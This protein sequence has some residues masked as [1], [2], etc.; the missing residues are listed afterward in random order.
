[1]TPASSLSQIIHQ[2]PDATDAGDLPDFG[3][4]PPPSLMD[5]QSGIL[6]ALFNAPNGRELA[7]RQADAFRR[8][9]QGSRQ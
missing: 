1:M 7:L 4:L 9:T 8:H 2:E 3:E 6:V 5:V